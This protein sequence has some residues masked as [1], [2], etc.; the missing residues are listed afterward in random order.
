MSIK[1]IKRAFNNSD[2]PTDIY[3]LVNG[4][5]KLIKRVYKVINGE[6]VIVW[7][8]GSSGKELIIKLTRINST[9]D[10]TASILLS[11]IISTNSNSATIDWGD[12]TSDTFN[13]A[14]QSTV[15]EHTYNSSIIAATITVTNTS[16]DITFLYRNF[17]A[18]TNA[19]ITVSLPN[20]LTAITNNFSAVGSNSLIGIDIPDSVISIGNSVFEGCTKLK[21][22]ILP[23]SVTVV[24]EYLCKHCHE[25]QKV[26]AKEVKTIQP[27]AFSYCGKLTDI[28][29]EKVELINGSCFYDC[30]LLTS[31]ILPKT[32]KY[33]VNSPFFGTLHDIYYQGTVADWNKITLYNFWHRNY[34]EVYTVHCSD[35]NIDYSS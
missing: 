12:G 8:I 15:F 21:E 19:Y 4:E 3:R 23:N 2:T 11:N 1:N 31:I 13:P 18:I 30:P 27:N 10:M 28:A 25:L 29:L 16:N 26:V 33:L 7:D 35:G 5:K 14:D 22:L 6:P 34:G 32:V 17:C 24:S 9:A 20:T